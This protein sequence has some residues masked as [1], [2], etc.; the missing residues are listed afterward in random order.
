MNTDYVFV[1]PSLEGVLSHDSLLYE[2][3]CRP[4]EI[5]RL[6]DGPAAESMNE[7]KSYYDKVLEQYFYDLY[8]V[9]M[10][11]LSAFVLESSVSIPE[12]VRLQAMLQEMIKI[13]KLMTSDQK[14]SYPYKVQ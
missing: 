5:L 14:M 9:F 11:K 12:T 10:K 13:K 4:T 6:L 3:I 8:G 1:S 2:G 7:R